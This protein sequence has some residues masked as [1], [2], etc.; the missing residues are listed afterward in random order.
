M[1]L[2]LLIATLAA[3]LVPFFAL[4]VLSVRLRDASIVDVYWGPGFIVI[5]GV[6]LA[7]G[8][9]TGPSLVLFGAVTVWAL[10]L[11]A[12]IGMR[13]LGEPHEDPRYAAMRRKAGD[14]FAR[15]SLVW[16]FGLQA[17]LQWL[18]A[19]P[20]IFALAWPSEANLALLVAGLAIFAAGLTVEAVGDWQNMRFRQTRSGPD[21]VNDRGLWGWSRH[22]NY[23][24]ETV[25]WWGLYLMA[26]ALG[27]P[28]W[29]AA[30]PA[31]MTFLLLRVS[32]VTLLEH[33]LQKRKPAYA[34]YA[35]RTSAFIPW[36]PKRRAS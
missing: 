18:V 4:W 6:A 5:A 31:L 30:S 14:A 3:A 16:V 34:D 7:F 8:G 32:G 27:A 9:V 33:G 35:R 19:M 23:F 11:G 36:P 24:G 1:D 12:H 28:W 26:L 21:A 10:R 25:L 15:E 22:P 29:T 20:L 17:V 2:K 13:K